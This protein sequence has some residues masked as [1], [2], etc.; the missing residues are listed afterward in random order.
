MP[1]ITFDPEREPSAWRLEQS[2][3]ALQQ[4]RLALAND[5]DLDDDEGAILAALGD[6]GVDDPHMLLARMIDAA[7]WAERRAHEAKS[8]EQEYRDRRHRYEAREDRLRSII[9]Q[10]MDAIET[11][12]AA[13][14]LAT[15][16][17]GDAPPSLVVTDDKAI[18]EEWWRVERVLRRGDLGK[19]MRET[20]EL[21]PGAYLSNGGTTLSMRKVR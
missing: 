11:K 18:P 2:I 5:P 15:A 1:E 9:G 6:M 16:T 17:I 21:V 7:V 10:M 8:L 19:H 12:R 14:K 20:G 13:G 3:A 4:V